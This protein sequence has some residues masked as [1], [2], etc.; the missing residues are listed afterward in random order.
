MTA[1]NP[2][3][4]SWTTPFG[5][6]PFAA[7]ETA[8]YRPAF[9]AALAAHVREIAA[10]AE[11]P[12]PPSFSNTIDAFERSGHA[13]DRIASV[14]FNLTG[15]HTNDE[16]DA[17]ETEIAPKFSRHYS[18][19]YLNDALFARIDAIAKAAPADLTDEQKRVLERY[20]TAFIRSGAGRPAEVKERIAAISE[21]LASLGTNFGQ[22]VLA[23]EK[24]WMLVLDGG[25]DLAGLPDFLV[26]AAAQAANDRELPGKYVITLSRSSIE[27]FLQ[28][29]ARRD[30]REQAFRAWAA[31]GEAGK[32]DN[33]GIIAETIALRAEQAR[34][35][36][37]PTFAHFRLDD[38]MAKTPEAAMG[39]LNSVWKPARERAVVEREAL[40]ALADAEGA[41]IE[42]ES[43]DWRFYSE[44][45]RKAEFDLDESRLKPYLQLDKVIE[46]AFDT[47]TRL[48]GITFTE[49]FDIPVY[50][51]DVR[52]FEVRD[53]DGALT[54][55]FLGDYFARPS[56]RSGAW[57]SSYRSQEKLSAEVRPIIVNVMNFAKGGAGEPTLLSF[58]DARTLFHEFGH[59]LHGLL[60]NVTY[61]LL[62]GTN[63]AR[64]FVEF[65]SQLYE[66]WFD[67]PEI[68]RKFA[69]HYRTGEPIP[70]ELLERLK[71]SRTFNQGFATVEYVASALVDLE[72][73]LL[74]DGG[75]LDAVAFEKKVLNDIGMPRAMAMRHRTP[76]FQ[77]V[78]AGDGYSSA[79]YSY[80]WSETLDADGF[81]AFEEAGDIFD[82]ETARR[83]RD[84]VYAAGNRRRPDEAYRA[85]RG[86]DPDPS[87]LLEKR[88]L[89]ETAV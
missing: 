64:D 81:R 55:I 68:L 71:A 44:K 82:P 38:S 34:L 21:R 62:A 78:F 74:P 43:W 49:R 86:R 63:V 80:L 59:G 25:D 18:A 19:I 85:F 50:H 10:I 47:A 30:L 54:G 26:A 4:D 88:G 79:Y 9:E 40:Q 57:M 33:R 32:T 15:A 65:P 56:K 37:Y 46:A 60:S 75:N 42:I 1:A 39:L 35:L 53:A 84:F 14:F 31:R 22:N 5:V 48:F 3:L 12:E 36:G 72:M 76:H 16:L 8:H 20:H 2:L 6:P 7:I 52:V 61:P 23:D 73:H 67:R 66:H 45:R 70:A 87:A 13:L 69:V 41:A 83:L 28:F 58:D 77:H 29:S 11:N 27:P 17:I 89:M 51:P 24:G